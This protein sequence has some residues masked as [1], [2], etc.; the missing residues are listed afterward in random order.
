MN[1]NS[2]INYQQKY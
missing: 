2:N 1:N